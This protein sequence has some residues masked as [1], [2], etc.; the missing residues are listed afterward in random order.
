M[1]ISKARL[2][3]LSGFIPILNL[4]A[5]KDPSLLIYSFFVFVFILRSRFVPLVS[6]IQLSATIKLVVL[7]IM[8]GFLTE[9]FVWLGEYLQRTPEPKML[10]PQLIPDLIRSVGFYGS[11]AVGWALLLKRY[12][13]TIAQVFIMQ[14]LYGIFIEQ[15]G[16]VFIIGQSTMPFGLLI[17]LY[18]FLVYG[19]TASLPFLLL[20]NQL[21]FEQQRDSRIKYVLALIVILISSVLVFTLWG[22]L[23]NWLL[24]EP[25]SIWQ[26]P[27]W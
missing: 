21:I 18:V 27:L 11:W 2:F 10:H 9:T 6:K 8:S 25:K 12:K 4:L 1:R 17:W 23:T 14:G 20:G 15:Q 3:V 22:L 7:I 13:F 24:P 26:S 16:A 5:R 19:A